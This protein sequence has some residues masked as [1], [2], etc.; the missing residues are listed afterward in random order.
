M[1][2]FILPKSEKAKTGMILLSI[3]IIALAF[4]YIQAFSSPWLYLLLGAAFLSTYYVR[5]GQNFLIAGCLMVGLG[6]GT[7]VSTGDPLFFGLGIGFLFFFIF[8]RLADK[9][10]HW[11]PLIPGFA[12]LTFDILLQFKDLILFLIRQWPFVVIVAGAYFLFISRRSK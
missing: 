9:N 8:S 7:A 1:Y 11:W 2:G 4:Q 6:T 3:G 12:L 5:G 10:A